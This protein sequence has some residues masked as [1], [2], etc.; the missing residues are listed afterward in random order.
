MKTEKSLF[1]HS[2]TKK[3]ALERMQCILIEN[4]DVSAGNIDIE[5]VINQAIKEM[6]ER[7]NFA[8]S[9]LARVTVINRNEASIEDIHFDSDAF[10]Q[11]IGEMEKQ[12]DFYSRTKKD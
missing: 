11:A 10:N 9:A 4:S 3:E 5:N 7:I 6:E 1:V 12:I 8:S 2:F